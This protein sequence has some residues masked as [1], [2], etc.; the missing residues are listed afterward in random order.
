MSLSREST[1]P[2]FGLRYFLLLVVVVL[3]LPRFLFLTF[4]SLPYREARTPA[5][6][7]Y[8]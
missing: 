3:L 7:S 2:A 6:D 4:V 1:N 8:S 5:L